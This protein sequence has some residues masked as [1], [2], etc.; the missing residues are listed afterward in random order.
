MEERSHAYF[1][2]LFEAGSEKVGS[3]EFFGGFLDLGLFYGRLDEFFGF[4]FVY[5]AD[6][7]NLSFRFDNFALHNAKSVVFSL[8]FE[9]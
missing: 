4:A 8:K 2:V 1:E 3:V 5:Y 6:W 7:K 9:F